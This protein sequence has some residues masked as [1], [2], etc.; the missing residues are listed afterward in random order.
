M[1]VIL[2]KN[3]VN[4]KALNFINTY[5]LNQYMTNWEDGLINFML[6]Y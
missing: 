1:R 3:E 4:V 6:Y 2:V 5:F